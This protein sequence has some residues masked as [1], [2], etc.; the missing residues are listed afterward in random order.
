MLGRLIGDK[1]KQQ[2]YQIVSSELK[3]AIKDSDLIVAN[4]ESP[5]SINSTTEGDHLQFA[6]NPDLLEE[7]DFVDIFSTANNH[8]TDCGEIG[9]S[10]TVSELFR[11]NFEPNGVFKDSY[12]PYTFSKNGCKYALVTLT[13]MLNIPFEKDSDWHVLRLGDEEINRIISKLRDSGYFVI[14]FA[15]VGMLFTRFPNPITRDYLHGYIDSG[16]DVIVTCH[17]HCLGGMEIYNGKYI[18]HSLG[19]FCMDGNSFRRRQAAILN[20]EIECRT[21]TNWNII[22]TIVTDDFTI[23]PAPEKVGG[24]MVKSFKSVSKQIESH[25]E[26]YSKFF[27][28]AYNKEILHHSFSTISFLLHQRGV[29]GLLRMIALRAGE[30]IRTIKWMTQD[31]SKDQRDDE[32]IKADRKKISQE[33]LFGK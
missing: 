25:S 12:E 7:F 21:I 1:Y 27:K 11:N 5:L 16:A 4:L 19:D 14:V 28:R 3:T 20:L 22:P 8:I 31:R 18:F 2:K 26:D 15:H 13:D 6:G 30:V 32:A 17:S 9:V 24:K 29:S 33:K 10:D 23:E